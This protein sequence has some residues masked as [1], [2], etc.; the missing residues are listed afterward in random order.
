MSS[1]GHAWG[2]A[3]SD[4]WGPLGP[5]VV[6]PLGALTLEL[7]GTLGVSG[8]VAPVLEEDLE[9]L[10]GYGGPDDETLSPRAR[11]WLKDRY[12]VEPTVTAAETKKVETGAVVHLYVEEAPDLAPRI[13]EAA[14]AAR[15]AFEEAKRLSREAVI[16]DNN[17]RAVALVLALLDD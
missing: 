16:K 1:W 6:H 10:I 2:N 12:K 11:K 7:R 5:E 8:G 13:K 17:R 9:E 15:E 14:V 4:A 3:W